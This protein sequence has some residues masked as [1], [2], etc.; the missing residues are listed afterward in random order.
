MD[1]ARQAL[2]AGMVAQFLGSTGPLVVRS[3]GPHRVTISVVHTI[4]ER[5]R[6]Q[7]WKLYGERNE[8]SGVI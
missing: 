7:L 2:L 6:Q 8:A 3:Y 4:I 1:L 5:G